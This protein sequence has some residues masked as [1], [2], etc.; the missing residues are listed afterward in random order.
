MFGV[1]LLNEK[2]LEVVTRDGAAI[3]LVLKPFGVSLVNEPVETAT[4]QG[5]LHA[6]GNVDTL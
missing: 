3:R 4:A 6:V 2:Q 5:L 1:P